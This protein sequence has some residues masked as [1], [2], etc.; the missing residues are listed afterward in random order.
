MISARQSAE[1]QAG[2]FPIDAD[3]PA[4]PPVAFRPIIVAVI[5]HH[6]RGEHRHGGGGAS[7]SSF[8]AARIDVIASPREL[9]DHRTVSGSGD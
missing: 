8:A 3:E 7:A 1:T 5:R 4:L 6:P 2:P 9:A